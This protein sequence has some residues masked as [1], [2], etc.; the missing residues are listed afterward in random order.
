V[1]DG[2]VTD[3]CILQ[4]QFCRAPGEIRGTATALCSASGFRDVPDSW[5]QIPLKV[6]RP[7]GLRIQTQAAEPF[8][9]AVGVE[10]PLAGHQRRVS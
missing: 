3:D 6:P 7:P 2:Q 9:A 5:R 1:S 4:F 8:P 10:S